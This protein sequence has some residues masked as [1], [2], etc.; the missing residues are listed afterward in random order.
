MMGSRN[1]K[2]KKK[3]STGTMILMAVLYIYVMVVFGFIFGSFFS[4]LTVFEEMGFGWAYFAFY[5][6]MSFALMLIGSA[7]I[8][9]SQ[10]FDAK[11]NDLLLSMPI[12]P[13]LI[14]IS[15][16]MMLLITNLL[17]LLAVLIP[18]AIVWAMSIGFNAVGLIFFIVLSTALWLF[19]TACG[20]LMGWVIALVSRKASNKTLVTVIFTLAFLGIYIY[21]YTS[22]QKFVALIIQNG[23]VISKGLKAFLPVY[24]FGTAISEGNIVNMLLAAAVLTV[25]FIIVFMILSK[26]FNKIVA[27]SSATVRIKEKKVSYQAASPKKAIFKREIARVFSSGAYLVNSGLGVIM[28]VI[29]AAVVMIKGRDLTAFLDAKPSFLLLIIT[30]GGVF[31]LGMIYF[32]SATISIEGK[33]LW[34]LRS[35]PISTKEILIA[36][37][38]LHIYASLPTAVLMW[39]AANIVSY[40]GIGYVLYTFIIIAVYLFLT[41]AVGLYE[42]LKHPMLD[43]QDET[44]A[45]KNGASVMLTVF[46]NMFITMAPALL[47]ILVSAGVP[48]IVVLAAWL[49]LAAGLTV[50]IYRWIFTKGVKRFEELC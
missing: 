23:E 45:V 22:A 40:S 47:F 15:R 30:F 21:F 3:N 7:A 16:V 19:S 31:M 27:D 5:A 43:W 11:D 42:N 36:K 13:S 4:Q 49:V 26:T 39:L 28:G 8:A 35:L 24:W 20:V 18:A 41:A 10:I 44:A 46:I 50:I 6:I 12:K 38:K 32:T 14:I 9:K 34:V 33:T 25:P 29:A 48:I 37:L 2:K 1:N 17:Y